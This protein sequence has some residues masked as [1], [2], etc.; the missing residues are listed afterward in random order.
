MS[1]TAVLPVHHR[2]PAQADVALRWKQ[3]DHD[4]FVAT[5]HDEFA[6]FISVDGVGHTVH[7]AHAQPLGV[8]RTLR[9]ARAALGAHLTRSRG[10]APR[11]GG[12]S[13][14]RPRRRG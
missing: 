11:P 5:L 7:S 3:A 8:Y 12:R 9:E 10:A 4:V 6:G 14:R 13:R 2:A 1:L